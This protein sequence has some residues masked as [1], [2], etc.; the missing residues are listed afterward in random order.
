MLARLVLSSILF[1]STSLFA[2]EFFPESIY[3]LDEKYTHHVIIVE[4]ST[5]TLYLYE[6]KNNLPKL[7]RSFKIA[8]GKRTGNK[9]AQGD[10]KTPEGIYFFKRFR[11]ASELV[12]A[13]GKVG[14][15]Y[16]A[17]AFTMNYPNLIDKKNGKTGSGIWLHSTD[18]DTRIS[19]GLDSRGCVV[20]SDADIKEISK[21]IELGNTPIIVTQNIS[22]LKKG[23][24][25]ANKTEI[26]ETIVEWAKAWKSNDFETYINQYS[27]SDFH[28]DT[29]GNFYSYKN[30]KRR[31]FKRPG[32]PEI[33][34]RNISILNF[35][36][37]A[38]V[39]MLQDYKSKS[40]NDIGKKT[41][42]LKRNA[43]YEWKIIS[44]DW[45]STEES[46]QGFV[47]MSRYFK[48]EVSDDSGSI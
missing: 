19:K 30:Y 37:Y 15:I 10:K 21:Y 32:E 12:S 38:V 3:Q 33:N 47:P 20:A 22:F 41:L 6:N 26:T 1:I 5:H 44:E 43:D 31:V 46:A 39:T 7:V 9:K 2:E 45:E 29:K 42:F 27:V 40:I 11:P 48:V 36:D 13:Y 24:W 34:F 23:T 17:G 4:K 8:T 16:G 18:D 28:S 25:D 35:K 14:L